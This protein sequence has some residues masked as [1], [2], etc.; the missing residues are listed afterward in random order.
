ML[1]GWSLNAPNFLKPTYEKNKDPTPWNLKFT[2]SMFNINSYNNW[3]IINPNSIF[4]EI[5][6]EDHNHKA[7]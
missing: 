7:R 5:F 1:Q 6:M 2:D 3:E 4:I